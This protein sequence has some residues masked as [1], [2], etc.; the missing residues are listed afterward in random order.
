MS[1]E[2]IARGTKGWLTEHCRQFFAD[3]GADEVVAEAQR[4]LRIAIGEEQPSA[5]PATAPVFTR[6]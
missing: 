6:K 3:S 4:N 5:A 2:S 1:L